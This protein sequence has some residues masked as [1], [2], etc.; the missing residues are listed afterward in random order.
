M[1]SGAKEREVPAPADQPLAQALKH[2]LR[3][4]IVAELEKR[5]MSQQEL[6]E[7]LGEPRGGADHES[8]DEGG[9]VL[10]PLPLVTY[11]YDVLAAVGLV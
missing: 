11:H 8:V 2:P 3:A 5:S 4:R 6:A 1:E 10:P 7:A 9:N